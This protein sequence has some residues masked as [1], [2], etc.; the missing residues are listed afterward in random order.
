MSLYVISQEIQQA[1]CRYNFLHRKAP[2]E[3]HL[4]I[5]INAVMYFTR[6]KVKMDGAVNLLPYG[7]HV[8]LGN[9]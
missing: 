8:R 1:T 5:I 2:Q 7:E 6:P 3:K 4:L 9:Q